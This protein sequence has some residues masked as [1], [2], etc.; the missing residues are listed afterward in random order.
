ML[1]RPI[2]SVVIGAGAGAAL[3]WFGQSCGGT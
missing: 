2:V 1:L 3:G